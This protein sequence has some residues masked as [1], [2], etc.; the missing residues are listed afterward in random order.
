LAQ[1]RVGKMV[2]VVERVPE[3]TEG[4]RAASLRC[5]RFAGHGCVWGARYVK[6]VLE[7]RPGCGAFAQL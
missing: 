6:R 7:A 3:S 4:A 5:I 2:F 1:V